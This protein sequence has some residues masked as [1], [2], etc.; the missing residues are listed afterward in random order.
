MPRRYTEEKRWESFWKA[1]WSSR[2]FSLN[3]VRSVR[4]LIVRLTAGNRVQRKSSVSMIG[5][6]ILTH[7][8]LC[9]AL[10]DTLEG[11]MG[12]QEGFSAISNCGLGKEELFSALDKRV[13]QK[14]D[15]DG[16]II[17]VDMF[18]TSCWQTAKK[19]VAQAGQDG[20]KNAIITGV[21]LPMLVKFFSLRASLPLEELVPLVK[22][23][24]EKGI[25][26]GS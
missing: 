25:R 18:G 17:F 7:G 15:G 22:Q 13:N 6:V 16:I 24:G 11:I 12:K 4:L 21:N 2:P 5:C 1:T 3:K 19:V 9:F 8:D 23:E 14:A 20:Q 10:K 26:T